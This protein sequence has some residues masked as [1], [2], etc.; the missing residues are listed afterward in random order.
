VV[1]A[2][3]LVN[4]VVNAVGVPAVVHPIVCCATD[5]ETEGDKLGDKLGLIDGDLLG[6]KLALGEILG[7]MLGLKDALGLI[8]GLKDALGLILGLIEGEMLG[9]IL[10]LKLAEA[11]PNTLNDAKEAA[12]YTAPE[13]VPPA[14]YVPVEDTKSS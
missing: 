13:Y 4:C 1:T 2:Y 8:L 7:L 10:G 5:G 14:L 11:A 9:E 6:L 12:Q 3:F